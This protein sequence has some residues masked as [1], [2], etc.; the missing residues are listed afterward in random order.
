M[1]G[2]GE[3]LAND[4]GEDACAGPDADARHGGQD[5]GKR[6]RRHEFLDL[7]GDFGAL[8][9]QRRELRGQSW[10]HDAGGVGERD[11]SGEAGREHRVDP[12]WSVQ[13]G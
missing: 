5:L 10:Q 12:A 1:P 11:F 4:L 3:V 7:F 13:L 8:L 2:G 9:P 6:V